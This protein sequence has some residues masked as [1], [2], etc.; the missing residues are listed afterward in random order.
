MN[1]LHRSRLIRRV[2]GVLAGLAALLAFLTT[3]PGASASQLRADPPWSVTHPG[4]F[5]DLP[6]LPP[7]YF[8]HPPPPDPVR[9][10]ATLAAGMPGWQITLIAF[11]TAVLAAAV[12]L[13]LWGR[14]RAARR[15]TTS[16]AA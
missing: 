3:G 9:L 16:A 12:A 5:V 13:L 10:H 6:P 14:T 11:S 15:T 2:A 7:G 1:P 8:K 4:L